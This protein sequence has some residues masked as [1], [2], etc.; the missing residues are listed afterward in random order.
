[1]CH[2]APRRRGL[3]ALGATPAAAWTPRPLVAR[4]PL[5]PASGIAVNI[6]F[7]PSR[8]RAIVDIESTHRAQPAEVT[9]TQLRIYALGYEEL[10]GRRA[11]DVEVDNLD[12]R[13]KKSRPVG[14]DFMNDV[15]EKVGTAATALRSGK[16]TYD[17]KVPR[18]PE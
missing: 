10:A 17:V 14:E 7:V 4:K 12:A 2:I 13:E 3:R 18:T 9:E 11:D 1:M 16:S 5:K 6:T 15:K 8:G